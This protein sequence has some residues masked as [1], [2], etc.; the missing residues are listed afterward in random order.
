MHKL[1]VPASPALERSAVAAWIAEAVGRRQKVLYKHAPVEDAAAVLARSLPEVGVDPAVLTSGQVQPADTTALRAETGGSHVALLALHRR[2]LGEATRAGFAGLALTGDAA[3]MLTITCDEHE[4]D[5]YE[6]G[7][8]R[9]AVEA[10]VPSLCRYTADQRRA[11]LDDMLTVHYRDVADD[12][13]SAEVAVLNGDHRLHVRGELD[14]S[15]ARRF[16][17]VVRAALGAGVRTLDASELVFCDVAGI[18][19][20]VSATDALPPD[21]LPLTVTGADG[22]LA[23]MLH[24]TG[25]L[26]SRALEM[27]ER[28]AGT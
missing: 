2:Q 24:L 25:A 11:L 23:S 21:A 12:V 16:V 9:L 14:F 1:L 4:L 8:E 19:A 6:R 13:W 22:V 27:G 7:L 26:N 3:A 20:L 5:G 18:R 28:E 10:G 17:P 15:N